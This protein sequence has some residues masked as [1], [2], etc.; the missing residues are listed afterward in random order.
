M[1]ENV[2]KIAVVGF[3]L[4]GKAT[5][6][7]QI[8]LCFKGRIALSDPRIHIDDIEQSIRHHRVECFV[9][10]MEN[11]FCVS[12]ISGS[13]FPSVFGFE[14]DNAIRGVFVVDAQQNRY[15]RQAECWSSIASKLPL[16]RWF[17]IV[18]KIDLNLIDKPEEIL[19]EV[20]I[21]G[22]RPFLAT[23]AK[24]SDSTAQI[25]QFFSEKLFNE[26]GLNR[27]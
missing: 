23:I 2:R 15:E 4:S 13:A 16:D 7:E 9:R 11:D 18:N 24:S 1:L 19:R 12:C 10:H 6:L 8:R 21:P 22:D 20:G 27:I 17:F 25:G 3:P 14:L 26:K 5:I